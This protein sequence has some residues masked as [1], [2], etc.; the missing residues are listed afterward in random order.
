MNN[1]YKQ[2]HKPDKNSKTAQGYY[3]VSNTDKYQGDPNLIIYRSSWEFA[4]C[5]WCDVSPSVK[6]WSSEPCQIKYY[7]RI[8][9]L[10]ETV[11]L[12]LDPN[13]QSNWK[14]R[15][16]NVDFW[17]E[18]E[19]PDGTTERWFIEVKPAYQLE[20]PIPPSDK[21]KPK[22]IKK[23]NLELK[24]YLINEAKFA[25]AN[26]YCK[27]INAKFYIFTEHVLE[28]LGILRFKNKR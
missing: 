5:K 17:L 8:S 25:A 10:S 7:D 26:A 19:L 2:W 3:H 14:I 1:S 13:A 20:K 15:N 12:G 27:S 23:Y 16:Y 6:R 28:K 24:T 9:N 4:L 18:I 21:A 11:K 22:E